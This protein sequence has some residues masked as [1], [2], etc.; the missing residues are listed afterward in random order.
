MNAV[1]VLVVT[2]K[3]KPVLRIVMRFLAG[4]LSRIYA[5]TVLT[6]I[7]AKRPA[8]KIAL[9]NG[10]EMPTKTTAASVMTMHQTMTPSMPTVPNALRI[11]PVF[12]TVTLM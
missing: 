10:A 1:I 6:V 8:E 4:T 2:P 5:V 7:L 9:V 12:G 3:S 11:V